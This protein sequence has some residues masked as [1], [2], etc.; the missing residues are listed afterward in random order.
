MPYQLCKA[1]TNEIL[2]DAGISDDGL[3]DWWTAPN[4]YLHGEE[5]YMAIHEPEK[6]LKVTI[7]AA[8]DMAERMAGRG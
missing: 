6:R 7:A 2:V 4:D 5:P 1:L 8:H 3:R